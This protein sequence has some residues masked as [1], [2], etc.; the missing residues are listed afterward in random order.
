MAAMKFRIE[1]EMRYCP[2]CQDE[3]RPGILVCAACG[4]ELLS[5]VQMQ[6]LLDRKRG[7]SA[8]RAAAITPEDEL[9]DIIKG[10]IINVKSV[11]ALLSREGIPSLIAGDSSSC[12]KGCGGTD[13]RLQVRKTDLPD[14]MAVLAREHVQTTGLTDHDTTLVDA[15]YDP[16]AGAATCP[17]CGCTFSTANNTCPD[18][19]LCF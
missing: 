2:Q 19:G 17:A 15:V 6:E 11:Q 5:G 16:E 3:Y 1:P 12:G 13:V 10:K 7:R 8:G 18:C 4:V 14:A 9:I